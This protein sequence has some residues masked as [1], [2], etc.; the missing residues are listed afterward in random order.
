MRGGD[1]GKLAVLMATA[2][3]DMVGA[4]MVFPLFPYYAKALGANAFMI[5]ALGAAFSATQLVSAPFWGRVSDRYGRKPTLLI[6][7]GISAAAYV[8]FAFSHSY[9][10]LLL[11]RVVQG[12]GGGTT[13]VISAYV[14]DA[15]EPRHR[16]RSLGWLSAAT[17]LGVV[18]GPLSG[19]AA[20]HLGTASPG[21]IAA[22]LCLVNIGFAAKYLTETHGTSAAPARAMR[23]RRRRRCVASSCTG[24]KRRRAS[25]GCTRWESGPSTAPRPCSC[26]IWIAPFR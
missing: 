15:V 24:A 14:A 6:G 3:I 16:A 5:S 20:T 9:W 7:L 18:L 11:S 1:A 21:L 25:S 19:S 17:N 12:A 23:G 26:S 10:L 8:V 4:L 22:C 13:G 2:F